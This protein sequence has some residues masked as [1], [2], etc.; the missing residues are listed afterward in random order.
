MLGTEPACHDD[1]V[2]FYYYYLLL[3]DLP[4]GM[5]WLQDPIRDRLPVVAVVGLV[6]V[7][8]RM[9]KTVQEKQSSLEK[10]F[11]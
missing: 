10:D 2:L 9:Q 1:V 7:S 8:E 5:A 4:M 6:F 3:M 11:W